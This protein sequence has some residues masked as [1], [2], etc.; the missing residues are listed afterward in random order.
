[1][2]SEDKFL[3]EYE[4]AQDSAEHHDTLIWTATGVACAANIAL[5]I[6]VL[7][8]DM[9]LNH[10]F[11]STLLGILGV[12]LIICV[13]VLASV[14]INLKNRK[15]NRCKYI[16]T[17]FGFRQHRDVDSYYP[18][19]LQKKVY[20]A[21]LLMF[22]LVWFALLL[23][24]WDR[25]YIA[26]IVSDI[27]SNTN[28]TTSAN[29]YS[30]SNILTLALVI[31]TFLYVIVTWRILVANRQVVRFMGEQLEASVRP[32]I[33]TSTFIVPGNRMI[34]LRICNTG[35][36]IA[37]NLRL[38]LDKDYYPPRDK[39]EEEYNLR[40]I[41]AFTKE[42][43]TFVPGAELIF[44]LGTGNDIF[45]GENQRRPRQFTIQAIYNFSGKT[46]SEETVLDLEAYRNSQLYPEEAI[47]T[48]LKN[49]E[50]AIRE[51]NK[52]ESNTS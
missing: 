38:K 20:Y 33:V 45:K 12:L 28:R 35:K 32:Y 24:A 26:I 44:Y 30:S 48:R 31:I 14:L 9:L 2:D 16:E 1:M 29:F 7:K 21:C 13:W 19:G 51:L 43:R 47:V 8:E 27:P 22:I 52:K 18:K 41:Y 6:F 4:K 39:Q 25:F 34:C 46:I 11:A 17:I 3:T 42:I 40:E 5:L 37:E 50:S 10:P 23:I 36:E 15:Y 49:I